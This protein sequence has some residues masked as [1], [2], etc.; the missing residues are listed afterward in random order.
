V[1]A[2]ITSLIDQ[3]SDIIKP[4]KFQKEKFKLSSFIVSKKLINENEILSKVNKLQ[5]PINI[6]IELP[7]QGEIEV[8][9]NYKIYK[10]IG[11]FLRGKLEGEGKKMNR[12]DLI[13]SGIWKDGKEWEGNGKFFNF[14]L[15]IIK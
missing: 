11:N 8:I 3:F 2:N 1:R 13:W 4:L 5:S 6:E 9:N 14:I 15:K 7:Q 12:E 10:Y